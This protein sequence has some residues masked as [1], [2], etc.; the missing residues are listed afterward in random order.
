MN[1]IFY[2]LQDELTDVHKAKTL[3]ATE[4]YIPLTVTG[5]L[6]SSASKLA[7]VIDFAK[8]ITYFNDYNYAYIA[9]FGRYYFVEN[10]ISVRVGIT[11][12]SFKLWN[13]F[14]T[15]SVIASPKYLSLNIV[16]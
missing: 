8:D 1:I 12:L 6:R 10:P 11:S 9:D 2:K 5:T 15:L 16:L 3:T 7:P 13:I 4:T 14:L